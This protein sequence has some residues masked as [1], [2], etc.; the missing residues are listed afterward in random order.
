MLPLIISAGTSVRIAAGSLQRIKQSGCCLYP[1]MEE[2]YVSQKLQGF[3]H[4]HNW[5]KGTPVAPPSLPVSLLYRRAAHDL[6][7]CLPCS[8]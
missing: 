8:A 3:H 5:A 7:D 6:K 4:G 2:E 1:S